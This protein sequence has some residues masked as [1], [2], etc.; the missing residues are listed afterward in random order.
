MF[1]RVTELSS[2]TGCSNIFIRAAKE[3]E[4]ARDRVEGG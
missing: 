4:T 1:G 2:S 3:L